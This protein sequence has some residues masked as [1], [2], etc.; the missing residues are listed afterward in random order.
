MS[1]VSIPGRQDRESARG[2]PSE[3]VLR[4]LPHRP[5]FLFVDRILEQEG[6]TIKTEKFISA[7]EAFFGGHY[8]QRP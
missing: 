8:P 3:E 7:D 4:L 5:P 6:T 1:E 2:V